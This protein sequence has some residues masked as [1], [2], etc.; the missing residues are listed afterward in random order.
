M[1]NHNTKSDNTLLLIFAIF[2]LGLAF[3]YGTGAVK[4]VGIPSGA[5]LLGSGAPQGNSVIG[6]PTISA[7]FIDQ[8]LAKYGSPAAG[9][10][11]SLYSYGQYYGIDPAYPLAFFWNESNFGKTGIASQTQGLGN[12]R[13]TPGYACIGG[14]RAYAS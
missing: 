5:N 7:A 9:T 14:F 2:L 8:M 1:E 11:S 10:G 6:S 4:N 12:I 13:C 3:I